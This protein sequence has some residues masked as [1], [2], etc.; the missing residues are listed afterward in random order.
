MNRAPG[1]GKA[2]RALRRERGLTQESLAQ[3]AGLH[4]NSI[5]VVERG[6]TLPTMETFF[7]IADG[8]GVEGY[9]L[10][11]AMNRRGKSAKK[12]QQTL[13][14]GKSAP[15]KRTVRLSVRAKKT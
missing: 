6:L 4:A 9:E 3:R 12:T 1:L 13:P 15:A 2:V 10:M 11:Y 8:L 5:S 14:A 7:A